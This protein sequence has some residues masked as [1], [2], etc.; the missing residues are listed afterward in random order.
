MADPKELVKN[1]TELVEEMRRRT[2]RTEVKRKNTIRYRHGCRP[3]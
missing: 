3:I 1:R 2:G